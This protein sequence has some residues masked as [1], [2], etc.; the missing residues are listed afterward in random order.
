MSGNSGSN[1]PVNG[2]VKRRANMDRIRGSMQNFNLLR[3]NKAM[4][5]NKLLEKKHSSTSKDDAL[6]SSP[7]L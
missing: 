7:E 1:S 5:E 6:S 2:L 4:A 3:K